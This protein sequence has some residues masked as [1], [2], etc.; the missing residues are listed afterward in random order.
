[1]CYFIILCRRVGGASGD[2]LASCSIIKKQVVRKPI[3]LSN[4]RKAA[5]D[6][7]KFVKGTT[8]YPLEQ[9]LGQG[10]FAQCQPIKSRRAD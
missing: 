6:H 2:P 3:A 1:M 5:A 7:Q 9:S 4:I 8:M 10:Y